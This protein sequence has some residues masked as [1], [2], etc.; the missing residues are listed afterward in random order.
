MIKH[1]QDDQEGI[2]HTVEVWE[3]ARNYAEKVCRYV[4]GANDSI[5]SL[6]KEAFADGYAKG[7]ADAVGRKA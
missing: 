4:D 3:L 6:V 7:Y 2:M 5:K 1:S